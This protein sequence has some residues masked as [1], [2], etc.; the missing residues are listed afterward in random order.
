MSVH[1]ASAVWGVECGVSGIKYANGA[2]TGFFP[3]EG[4]TVVASGSAPTPTPEQTR[5]QAH[6]PTHEQTR[7]QTYEQTQR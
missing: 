5:A 7:A 1:R 3:I 4:V 6:E 2:N